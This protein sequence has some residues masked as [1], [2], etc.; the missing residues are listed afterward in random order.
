MNSFIAEVDRLE[1]KYEKDGKRSFLFVPDDE[2]ERFYRFGKEYERQ[3][4]KKKDS[5]W[6]SYSRSKEYR[7]AMN[8]FLA[9]TQTSM[10]TIEKLTEMIDRDPV[11]SDHGRHL[12]EYPA[13]NALLNKHGLKWKNKRSKN[14]R[15]NRKPRVKQETGRCG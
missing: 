2:C 13:V 15:P 8:E 9:K 14:S 3:H 7:Q 10:Y 12:H 1:N 6:A 11:L 5:H 4:A